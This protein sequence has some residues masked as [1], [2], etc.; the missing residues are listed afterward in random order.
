MTA[1]SY[2][3]IVNNESTEEGYALIFCQKPDANTPDVQTYAWLSKFLYPGVKADFSW[4]M[5]WAFMWKQINSINE[6]QQIVLTDLQTNN[7]ITLD[8]DAGHQ[9]FHFADQAQGDSPGS[10]YIEESANVPNGMA[11]VGL[12]L[13]GHPAFLV[14]SQPNMNVVITPKPSYF[15]MFGTHEDQGPISIEQYS[16]AVA[17]NYPPNIYSLTATIRQDGSISVENSPLLFT[18][19]S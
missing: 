3:L 6:S 14:N 12:A 19:E 8:Y 18:G 1:P 4:Q 15:L 9:A 11:Q 5:Q 16:K 13:S 2:N 7:K 17:L 10:L